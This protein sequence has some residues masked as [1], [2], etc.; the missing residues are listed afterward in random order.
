MKGQNVNDNST[1]KKVTQSIKYLKI[2]VYS[3][4]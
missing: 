1:K 4:N 2:K 3:H